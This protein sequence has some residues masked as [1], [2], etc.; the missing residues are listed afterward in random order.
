MCGSGGLLIESALIGFSSEGIDLDSRLLAKAKQN[1]QYFGVTATLTKGDS[2]QLK[3]KLKHTALD[4]P[5][6]RGTTKKDLEKTYQAM[7]A[8]LGRNLTG[9]AVIMYP[10]WADVPTLVKKAGLSVR[11]TLE[12]YSHRLLTRKIVVCY[13]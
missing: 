11:Y 12:A 4:L 8:M 7:I 2:T 9:T 1:L 6:G 3:K 10:H 5:Y 13:A